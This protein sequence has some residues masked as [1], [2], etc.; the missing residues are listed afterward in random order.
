MS[1]YTVRTD[2]FMIDDFEAESLDAAVAEAFAGEIGGV[3]DVASLRKK[4]AKYE[5]DGGWCWVEEDGER[6]L[7]IGKS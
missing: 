5:A 4:F 2:A 6:V 3:K 7:E 1:L